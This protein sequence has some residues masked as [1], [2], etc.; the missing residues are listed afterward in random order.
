MHSFS[1]LC[2]FCIEPHSG[3]SL[4]S[5]M[6][7]YVV[8]VMFEH[9]VLDHFMLFLYQETGMTHPG[10]LLL[11]GFQNMRT[12]RMQS[13]LP[14]L[15]H[16]AAELSPEFMWHVH[17]IKGAFV[18]ELL[19]V[20]VCCVCHEANLYNHSLFRESFCFKENHNPPRVMFFYIP[21]NSI[22]TSMSN[23]HNIGKNSHS[24]YWVLWKFVYHDRKKMKVTRILVKKKKKRKILFAR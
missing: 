6:G 14:L 10:L 21:R 18:S 4:A 17:D 2:L 19:S 15:A 23:T 20:V 13:Q 12:C 1:L 22:S 8:H 9:K 24:V 5:N 3:L 16:S 11:P 7:R